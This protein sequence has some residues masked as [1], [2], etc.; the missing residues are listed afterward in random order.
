MRDNYDIVVAGGGHAGCEAALAAARMGASTLLVTIRKNKIAEMS[1]NPAIGGLAKGHLVK[2]IDA[3]GGEMGRITDKAMLQFRMLNR[4][5]GPAVWSPRAQSD[6]KW[7]GLYMQESI[8]NQDGLDVLEDQVVEVVT[9][10]RHLKG[11]GVSGGASVGCKAAI[12]AC[13]TFLNGLIH[14]GAESYPA[15]RHGEPPA[16][17]LT[18]SLKSVGFEVGRFKTG[19][20]PRLDGATIDYDRLGRQDSEVPQWFSHKTKNGNSKAVLD[21]FLPCYWTQ[22]TEASHRLVRENLHLSALY[23]GRIKGTGPR[24]CP[25]I[26]DK[27]VRFDHRDHHPLIVEPEGR[28]NPEMYLNGLSTSLPTNVQEKIL[29]TIP[30]LEKVQMTRAAYAI[31]YDYF[32]PHQVELTLESRL[33]EGLY[34]AGQILGTSGYEEAAA[35]GL[36][37]GINAVRKLRSQSP[38]ILDRSQAYIGVLIDDLVTKGTEEPYRMF[39]S[40]AEWR[41]LLRQDNA[42]LRLMDVGNAVGLIDE[43]TWHRLDSKRQ[44]ISVVE[45][46][47][48]HAAA[49]EDVVEFGIRKGERLEQV[50]RRPE[51]KIRQLLPYF[52]DLEHKRGDEDM[53]EDALAQVSIRVKYQ[54]Y[55]E[56]QSRQVEAFRKMEAREIPDEFDYRSIRELS[57]EGREKLAKI[58]PRSF[59]QASRISGVSHGDLAVLMVYLKRGH[60]PRGTSEDDG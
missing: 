7:Y 26:E 42:D 44:C 17:G 39:P 8:A 19:T 38:V 60:V 4:G 14:R 41:L 28:G 49:L 24:Y 35:L 16:K 51:I 21:S 48:A 5:K 33:I 46:R 2:E 30:G 12:L 50:L 29:H 13:G 3:L 25:S 56:R 47:L 31:E 57:M 32:P 59:G 58:R 52:G 6:R 54:G 55:L 1:C 9:D 11:V 36:M 34:L 53:W 20:P 43:D 18:E 27:V 23:S 40:R 22:T 15:G 45:K 37:A 10:G